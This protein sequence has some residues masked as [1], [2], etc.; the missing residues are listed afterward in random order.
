MDESPSYDNPII[1][2]PPSP[3]PPENS[4]QDETQSQRTYAA[5]KQLEV[6]GWRDIHDKLLATGT[7]L[8]APTSFCCMICK[9]DQPM[10]IYRCRDCGPTATFCLSCLEVHHE[11]SLHLPEVWTNTSTCFQ[12][13]MDPKACLRRRD[14]HRCTTTSPRTVKVYD[15]ADVNSSVQFK[16]CQ[17]NQ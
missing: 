16:V 11:N 9:Q 3:P 4:A 15:D 12:P 14:G 7:E 13:Y 2:P 8:S 17:G 10:D 5:H 1:H 6:T